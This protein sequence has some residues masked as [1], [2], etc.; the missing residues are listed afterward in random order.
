MYCERSL[1]NSFHFCC[2]LEV[3]AASIPAPAPSHGSR[4]RQKPWFWVLQESE[5]SEVSRRLQC[6]LTGWVNRQAFL[7]TPQIFQF[8]RND[9]ERNVEERRVMWKPRSWPA[10][11]PQVKHQNPFWHLGS[12]VLV[13]AFE[14]FYFIIIVTDVFGRITHQKKANFPGTTNA[15]TKYTGVFRLPIASRPQEHNTGDNKK[16]SYVTTVC[17]SCTA[18]SS[19]L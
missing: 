17:C 12:L 15:V 4:C 18:I 11:V 3:A 10:Y 7:L 16:S 19:S 1:S 9:E 2:H 8:P 13:T 5:R 6:L 14:Y